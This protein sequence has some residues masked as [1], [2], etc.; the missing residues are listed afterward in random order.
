M[1]STKGRKHEG[2]Q[3]K[4]AK[5]VQNL[6]P[7]WSLRA[8]LRGARCSGGP[9]QGAQFGAPRRGP[10][11]FSA[12]LLRFRGASACR[13]PPKRCPPR[14]GGKVL[15]G[16]MK[17][18]KAPPKHRPQKEGGD[19]GVYEPHRSMASASRGDVLGGFC[20]RRGQ[21]PPKALPPLGARC[22]RINV[23]ETTTP[24][25]TPNYACK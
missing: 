4:G 1:L 6:I 19:W 10:Q 3:S 17:C 8:P 2:P 5:Q 23:H 13:G 9:T 21:N 12:P 7:A 16:F 25:H 20:P 14:S 11:M 15:G 22:P 24:T 18:A